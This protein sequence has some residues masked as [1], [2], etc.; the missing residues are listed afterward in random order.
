MTGPRDASILVGRAVG[1]VRDAAP[2]AHDADRRV[3]LSRNARVVAASTVYR[4][5]REELGVLTLPSGQ[6][7]ACDPTWQD[8]DRR[9]FARQVRPGRYP[10]VLTTMRADAGAAHASVAAA[11]LVL[12]DELPARWELALAVGQRLADLQPGQLYGY[13]VD[14][15]TGCFIDAE[16]A[17]S[18]GKRN[19][20]RLLRAYEGSGFRPLIHV[21]KDEPTIA[22]FQS[23]WGDGF[24]ASYWG[25]DARGEPVCL[26]TDFGLLTA[27][28]TA[29]LR[30]GEA[31]GVEVG[32]LAHP[33][34]ARVGATVAITEA[35]PDA[36]TV[37]VRGASDVAVRL[38]VPVGD[39]WAEQA[40][41]TDVTI[42]EGTAT[43]TLKLDPPAPRAALELE[44][45]I[46]AE[47]LAAE[48]A[49]VARTPVLRRRRA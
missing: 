24:Y 29:T 22:V 36:I 37:A 13:G 18:F 1:E 27:P 2:L 9:P 21:V 3:L 47:M 40:C 30:F 10:V 19:F 31:A 49:P 5:V 34:L 25:L 15:G 16:F 44:V 20:Q 43:R 46:G 26:V 4:A 17:E 32:V 8:F 45:T 7:L 38:L 12:R 48:E 42:A 11:A 41:A 28:V 23:G 33:V 39:E 35:R 14:G 6:V